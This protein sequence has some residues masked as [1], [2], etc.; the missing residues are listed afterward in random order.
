VEKSSQNPIR[1]KITNAKEEIRYWFNASPSTLFVS[2]NLQISMRQFHSGSS[3]NSSNPFSHINSKSNQPAMVD[4]SDKNI[5]KRTAHARTVIK[6]PESISNLFK[7]G[8]IATPKGPVFATAIIAGTMGA[9]KTSELIPFCH[10][11]PL[12]N[13]SIQIQM[14]GSCAI[15]DCNVSTHHKTGV[16]MEALTG[17][18]VAALAFYDM[19]KSISHDI[20]IQE[21]MLIQKTG[22]KSDINK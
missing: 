17:A 2:R 14:K 20:V 6:L 19:C 5:S 12:E 21:T 3:E 11:L 16:E 18:S 4:V 10:P 9:K 1:N 7:N 22:G 15:I 8:E 13:C